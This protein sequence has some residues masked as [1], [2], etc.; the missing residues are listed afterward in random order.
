MP[1][2]HAPF[3][4]SLDTQTAFVLS[5]VAAGQAKGTQFIAN[6]NGSGNYV[7]TEIALQQ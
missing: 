3:P 1:I 2:P 6:L 4:V 7:I 5:S